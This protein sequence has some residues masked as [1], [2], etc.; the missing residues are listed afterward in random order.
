MQFFKYLIFQICMLFIFLYHSLIF[1]YSE[2]SLALINSIF[3]SL[4]NFLNIASSVSIILN[5]CLPSSSREMYRSV[6]TKKLC[7][8]WFRK[9]LAVHVIFMFRI[10]FI[11]FFNAQI[12]LLYS[13]HH[14]YLRYT[15]FGWLK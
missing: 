9:F 15:L 8:I 3:V 1:F 4:H 7:S 10:L 6:I 13:E 14:Q 2:S 11:P 12:F 5:T